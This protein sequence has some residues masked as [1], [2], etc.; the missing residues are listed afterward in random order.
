MI[1]GFVNK[2]V[3][4]PNFELSYWEQTGSYKMEEKTKSNSHRAS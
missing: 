2:F 4:L 3:Y 1:D